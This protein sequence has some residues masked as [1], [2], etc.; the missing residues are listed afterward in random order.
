[1]KKH[2]FVFKVLCCIFALVL[3][4]CVPGSQ[5][6]NTENTESQVE[7]DYSMYPFADMKWMRDTE[8]DETL[9]FLSNGEFRYSCACGSPV[10]DADVVESYSYDDETK[11]FTLNCYEELEGM[12]TEIKLIRCDDEVLELDFNGEIRVFY[13]EGSKVEDMEVDDT[14][15]EDTDVEDTDVDYEVDLTK[16]SPM[17]QELASEEVIDAAKAVI[18]AFLRYEDSVVIEVSGNTQRFM[19]DMGY[20]IHCTC[21]M[22]GA[23]TDFNEMNAYDA[24]T[25]TVSWDYFIGESEFN[26]KVQSFYE[27]AE[28]YLS[29]VS[30][31]D[32]EAMRA[33]LLYYAVIDDL[34]YDYDLIGDKYDSL[35]EEEANL[36]SSPY[37]VLVEKSGIC[38]NIAQAYMFLCT[39]ADI[40]CGTV[41]HTG[42]SGMHMWNTVQVDG[43]YYY[44]DPTWDANTSMKYFGITAADRASWAGE[45]SA[46]EGTMLSVTIPDKYSVTDSRFEVLRGKLPVEISEVKADKDSQTITFVGYEYEYVFECKDTE[47]KYS[48]IE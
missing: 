8:C 11:L 32:S 5:A 38:T 17:I 14:D 46:S 30:A 23:F 36:K 24:S 20:V 40:T 13:R 21:P 39:Q 16:I 18:G 42:G 22:F 26:A 31:T 28:A 2:N 27:V 44:C 45:Y 37:C 29:N 1:M 9:C 6:H 35:S 3:T 7:I 43:K 10:N 19:N 34:N 33:M 25:G 47:Q 41:L 15:V 4:G 12:I 48:E